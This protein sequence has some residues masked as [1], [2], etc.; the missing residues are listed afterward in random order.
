MLLQSFSFSV[1]VGDKPSIVNGKARVAITHNLA[2]NR[3]YKTN[4]PEAEKSVKVAV[5]LLVVGDVTSPVKIA[6]AW[7]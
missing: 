5:V 2:H 1:C 7:N 4:E 6:E 3:D